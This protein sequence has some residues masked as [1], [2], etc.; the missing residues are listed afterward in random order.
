MK[1][2]EWVLRAKREGGRYTFMPDPEYLARFPKPEDAPHFIPLGN[3]MRFKQ[4]WLAQEMAECL[5]DLFLSVAPNE[6]TKARARARGMLY[7]P[8][9][10]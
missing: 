3:A 4:L 6:R 8:Y 5:N 9:E 1:R 2:Q 7:E 10:V